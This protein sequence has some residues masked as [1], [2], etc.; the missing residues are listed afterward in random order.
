MNSKLLSQ[1][2]DIVLHQIKSPDNLGSVVRLCAN[3]GFSAPKLSDP[4]TYDVRAA[5]RTAVKG[6]HIL[7]RLRM[8]RSLDEA[9]QGAVFTVGTTSRKVER[10]G[11]LTPEEGV[12]LLHEH[13]QRGRVALVFGGETRG[14][15]DEELNLCQEMIIIP[16]EDPQPSMNLAQSAAV[17]LYLA[18]RQGALP[19]AAPME[20]GAPHSLLRVLETRMEKVLLKAGFLNANAPEHIRGE[21]YRSLARARLSQR[22]AELWLGAFAQLTRVTDA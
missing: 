5:Q 2:L 14:L 7:E 20:P 12:K 18:S 17:L 21:L 15:S 3:F 9:L 8:E 6:E 19:T 16:T 4:A 10:R 22:E 13:A 1:Q 11:F